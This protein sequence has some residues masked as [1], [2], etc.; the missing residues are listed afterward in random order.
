MS[1]SWLALLAT[2]S[3][4]PLVGC[5]HAPPADTAVAMKRAAS[6]VVAIA[7]RHPEDGSMTL[8]SGA[9]V[10]PNLVL[11]ARHC[12][13]DALTQTPACD[14]QGLSHNGEHLAGDADPRSIS[15]YVGTHI[16]FSLDTP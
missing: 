3:T 7:T 16:D 14:A 2:L 5:G 13:S 4:L 11:T 10:A 8:C 9:L 12:V 15:I 1:P 6:G